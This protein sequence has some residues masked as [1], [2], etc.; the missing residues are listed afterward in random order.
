MFC[1]ICENLSCIPSEGEAIVKECAYRFSIW[2]AI[3]P[4]STG[5]LRKHIP[6]V[7]VSDMTILIGRLVDLI[8]HTLLPDILSY[9][10][11]Y[12]IQ[13]ILIFPLVWLV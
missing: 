10:V 11:L 8:L 3:A 9:H 12:L 1:I 5:E 7:D 6:S 13:F 4:R 2:L